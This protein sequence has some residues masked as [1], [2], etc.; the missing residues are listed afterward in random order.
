MKN[1]INELHALTEANTTSL[2]FIPGAG[3]EISTTNATGKIARALSNELMVLVK[4]VSTPR[5]LNLTDWDWDITIANKVTAMSPTDAIDYVKDL[6][7]RVSEVH[8]IGVMS[9]AIN[10]VDWLNVP[11]PEIAAFR[12]ELVKDIMF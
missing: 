9:E 2:G 1:L 4:A 7:A 11:L 8:S 5:V 12:R 3:I 6:Q 10:H